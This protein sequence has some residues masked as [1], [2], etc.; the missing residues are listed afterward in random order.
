[1]TAKTPLFVPFETIILSSKQFVGEFNIAGGDSRLQLRGEF[2]PDF[3]N[4][5]YV[6]QVTAR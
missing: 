4:L 1:V 2:E 6:L 5:I 3:T